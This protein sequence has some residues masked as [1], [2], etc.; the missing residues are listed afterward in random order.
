MFSELWGE[1]AGR[2]VGDS[3]ER[4]VKDDKSIR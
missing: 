2:L 3:E 4:R 1:G